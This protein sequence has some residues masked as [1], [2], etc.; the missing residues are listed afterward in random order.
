M[1]KIYIVQGDMFTIW[2]ST[3]PKR[4]SR[5]FLNS[6]DSLEEQIFEKR[7]IFLSDNSNSSATLFNS[8][9]KEFKWIK[10]IGLNKNKSLI[11]I[12]E[13]LSK[14]NFNNIIYCPRKFIDTSSNRDLINNSKYKKFFFSEN[15]FQEFNS[16]YEEQY[17]RF[18]TLPTEEIQIDTFEERIRNPPNLDTLKTYT[19]Y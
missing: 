15:K 6:L 9:K 10:N 17:Q 13:L 5:S 11:Q 14:N 7:F 2:P 3:I 8:V 16:I 19:T 1:Q 4:Y 12:L 18:T